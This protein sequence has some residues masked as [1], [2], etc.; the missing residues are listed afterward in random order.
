MPRYSKEH[1][2]TGLRGKQQALRGAYTCA[3]A[4]PT[5]ALDCSLRRRTAEPDEANDTQCS[6]QSREKLAG[7]RCTVVRFGETRSY[8]MYSLEKLVTLSQ[9]PSQFPIQST[10]VDS[11]K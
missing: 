10:P 7:K 4:L 1:P 5:E 11:P 8:F 9:S 2:T 3:K 6:Q